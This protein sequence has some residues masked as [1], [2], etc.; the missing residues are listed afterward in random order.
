MTARTFLIIALILNMSSALGQVSPKIKGKKFDAYQDSIKKVDYAYVLPIWGEK[1]R[2]AGIDLQKPTGIM[3][4]FYFQEQNLTIS[5]LAVSFRNEGELIDIDEFTDF[6]YINT[7]NSV[8]TIRPDIW[9]FPFMN[10]YLVASR[11]EAHTTARLSVP[12][13]LDIPPVE[14]IGYGGGFGTILAYGWGPVWGTANLTMAWSKAPGLDQPT[15]SFVGSFRV[16]TSYYT[17]NRKRSGSIW[18]GSNFQSYL[19]SNTGSYDMT[20]LLPDEKPRLE[21]LRQKVE[22]FQEELSGRY[23]E[24]CSQPGNKPT[25]IIMDQVLEEFKGRIEDKIDGLEPPELQINFGYN[26]SP[27]KKW[28]MVTGIQLNINR[29]WQCQMEAGFIGRRS[30]LFSL[31]YRFGILRKAEI[32]L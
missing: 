1:A 31:S 14:K 22:E 15:Q 21:E 30:F 18:V 10:V 24:Y 3:G 9:L 8:Y 5:N 29:S 6:E 2:E 12:F 11:F 7:R 27:E 32:P 23:E 17:R 26:V 16:G 19:G 13:E 25:C 20:Q 4:N 28:N